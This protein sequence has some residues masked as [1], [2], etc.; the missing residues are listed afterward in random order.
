[1]ISEL[2]F[3]GRPTIQVSSREGVNYRARSPCSGKN[4]TETLV[5]GRI[6]SFPRRNEQNKFMFFICNTHGA[7]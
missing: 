4:E 5:L 1:M 6:N 2:L 7:R 3:L